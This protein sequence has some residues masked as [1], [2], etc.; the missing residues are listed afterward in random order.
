MISL[1]GSFYA[2]HI[3]GM[4]VRDLTGGFNVWRAEVLRA[5][6]LERVKSEGYSFQI[7]LKYRARQ[8]G[9]I[10]IE[11]PILFSERREGQSKM[12]GAI[13]LEAFYRVWLL[14]FG[15]RR[16]GVSETA[17]AGSMKEVEQ[18]GC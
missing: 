1:A 13:V 15:E 2:R 7:E 9:F 3:L 18:A 14:R 5:I 10:L 11:H 16:L 4:K 17:E 8:A 12:S 6:G